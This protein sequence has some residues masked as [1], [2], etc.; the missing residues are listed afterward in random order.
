MTRLRGAFTALRRSWRG[1]HE[2]ALFAAAYLA[3]FGVRAATEGRVPRA[4]VNAHD[5]FR[6]EG[7]LRIDWERRAQRV[8]VNSSLLRSAADAI[9]MW[10]H[11]PV[12]IIGG[13]L[14]FNLARPQYFRLR[15]VCL[16]SGAVGLL[17]FALF[18]V[19]PPRLAGLGFV[20]TITLHAG[21]YRKVLPPSLVNEYAAM[22]SFHAGWNLMLGVAL[23][24]PPAGWPCAHWPPRYRWP[25]ASQPSPPRTT[26]S[27]TWWPAA[28]SWC[29][30][31]LLIERL[32]RG[33]TLVADDSHGSARGSHSIRRTVR[34]RDIARGT[35]ILALQTGRAARRTSRRG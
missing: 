28:E 9:Y 17:V 26:S 2:V 30:S 5:L 8:V 14:L 32:E 13:I 27:W 35:S 18:P 10:G 29:L 25:W 7:T 31:F 22:P 3:Y 20:D 24:R 12:L 16:L 4:V 19:A 11:W 34:G 23:F 1:P 15:N 21:G 33:P 6:L